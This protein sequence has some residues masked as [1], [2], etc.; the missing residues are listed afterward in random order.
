MTTENDEITFEWE[1]KSEDTIFIHHV[2]GIL[3]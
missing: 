2:I 3:Q 1:E